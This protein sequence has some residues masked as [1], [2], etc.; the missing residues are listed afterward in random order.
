MF[1][2]VLFAHD[3]SRYAKNSLRCIGCM[4]IKELLIIHVLDPVKVPSWRLEEAKEKAQ[5]ALEEEKPIG[6]KTYVLVEEGLPAKEIIRAANKEEVSL[7]IMGTRRMGLFREALLGSVSSDVLR[8]SNKSILIIRHKM[9]G[10]HLQECRENLFASV[11]YATNFS[12]YSE[13]ALVQLVKILKEQKA[14]NV[15][16]LHIVDKGET[17]KE[18]KNLIQRAEMKL[19]EIADALRG[20]EVETHVEVGEPYREIIRYTESRGATLIVLEARGKGVFE[21]L[22]I[23]STSENVVR[24]G[25]KPCRVLRV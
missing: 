17:E 5:S 23:G 2:R 13:R 3:L 18:I 15:T 14:K 10:K 8:F 25:T 4:K 16:L 9:L 12:E 19:R 24:H 6:V 1:D 11:L 22:I 21:E 20:V 7:I